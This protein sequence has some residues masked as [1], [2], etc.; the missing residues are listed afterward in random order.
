VAYFSVFSRNLLLTTG[1]I[2]N[3]SK[4]TDFGTDILIPNIHDRNRKCYILAN[5]TTQR[6]VADEGY[7]Y[8]KVITVTL[9]Q[10]IQ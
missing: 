10:H 6:S 5:P 2:S 7:N 9:N 1:Y 3:P 8:T 4:L